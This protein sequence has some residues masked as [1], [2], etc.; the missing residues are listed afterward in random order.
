LKIRKRI[1]EKLYSKILK[2]T[3]NSTGWIYEAIK[4]ALKKEQEHE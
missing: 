2:D 4:K 3:K 1:D